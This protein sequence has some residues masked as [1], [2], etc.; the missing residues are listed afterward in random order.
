[1]RMLMKVTLPNEGA[2]APVKDGSLGRIIGRFME[3]NRPEASYFITEGGERTALFFL[4][5]KDS[6]FIPAL[7]EPFFQAL[8]A[9]ISFTPAMNPPDLQAGLEKL[10]L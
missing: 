6:T 1:M 8:N 2:N 10:K 3:E 5:V 9:R 7:A 4:D